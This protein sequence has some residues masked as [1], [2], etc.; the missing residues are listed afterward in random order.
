MHVVAAALMVFLTSTHR[1]D[2]GQMVHLLGHVRQ[3]LANLHVTTGRNGSEGAAV[4]AAGLEVPNVNCR[5]ASRHPK[6]N[7]RFSPVPQD[8]GPGGK[9]AGKR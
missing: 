6:Q 8:V 2:Y 5:W 9:F 3:V 4:L 7:G 1:T